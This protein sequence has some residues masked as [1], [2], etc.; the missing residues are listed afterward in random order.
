MVTLT[1]QS[2][3]LSTAVN[4]APVCK[5]LPYFWRHKTLQ[6]GEI[7]QIRDKGMV[8]PSNKTMPLTRLSDLHLVALSVSYSPQTS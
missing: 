6:C 5:T 4:K 3:L 1:L 8:M 7:L 2:L